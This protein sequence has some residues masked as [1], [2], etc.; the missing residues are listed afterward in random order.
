MRGQG[1]RVSAGYSKC[2]ARTTHLTVSRGSG[3]CMWHSADPRATESLSPLG[4]LGEPPS[5]FASFITAYQA[6][7]RVIRCR[8]HPQEAQGVRAVGTAARRWAC[9]WVFVSRKW[10]LESRR[11][12][13]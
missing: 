11:R 5:A 7:I 2:T 12:C 3:A 1:R 10:C 6:A 8:P 4:P 9:A 13:V